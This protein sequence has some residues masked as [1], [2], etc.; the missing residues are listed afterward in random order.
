MAWAAMGRQED[1]RQ[2]SERG[3]DETGLTWWC[4]QRGPSTVPGLIHAEYL[5]PPHFFQEGA[6]FVPGLC[7]LL[8]KG[9]SIPH[10]THP[11]RLVSSVF[12]IH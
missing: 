3:L 12:K 8:R 4:Q 1:I 7:G 6:C 10:L 11:R 5:R 2:M 9:L